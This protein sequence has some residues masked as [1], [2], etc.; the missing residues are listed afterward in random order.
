[1]M[2]PLC[3]QFLYCCI[4]TRDTDKLICNGINGCKEAH[5]WVGDYFKRNKQN[6]LQLSYTARFLNSRETCMNG[7]LW[8]WRNHEWPL[9]K[10]TDKTTSIE[11]DPTSFDREVNWIPWKKIW[12]S[13]IKTHSTN[14][15]PKPKVFSQEKSPSFSAEPPF[16]IDCQ[17]E[18]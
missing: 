10:E 14:H 2:W 13:R 11:L 9:S 7:G 15:I 4:S 3:C 1:M 8:L 18:F 6:P 5:G 16:E 12:L 17:K